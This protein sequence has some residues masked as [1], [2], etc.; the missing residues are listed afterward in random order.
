VPEG[1]LLGGVLSCRALNHYLELIV[2]AFLAGSSVWDDV[3]VAKRKSG[4]D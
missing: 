4:P 1:A 3:E 2:G